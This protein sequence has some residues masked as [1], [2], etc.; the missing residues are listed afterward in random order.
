MRKVLFG[1]VL[2][3][4][5]ATS[6]CASLGKKRTPDEFAVEGYVHRDY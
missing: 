3:A 4:A 2:V 6:G 5:V 1:L